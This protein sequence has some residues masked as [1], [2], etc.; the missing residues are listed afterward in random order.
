MSKIADVGMLETPTPLASANVGNGDT[1]PPLKHADVLN[2]WSLLIFSLNPFDHTVYLMSW[3]AKNY[4][5][6]SM[7]IVNYN[8]KIIC[9]RCYTLQSTERDRIFRYLNR[10]FED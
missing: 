7:E 4:D 1:P 9:L 10:A 8:V 6:D 2:G 5:I 3:L